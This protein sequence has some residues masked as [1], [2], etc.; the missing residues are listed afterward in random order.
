M[1]PLELF[2]SQSTGVVVIRAACKRCRLYFSNSQ[3]PSTGGGRH[4]RSATVDRRLGDA[5]T[6]VQLGKW[7]AAAASLCELNKFFK[8]QYDDAHR[9]TASHGGVPPDHVNGKA[10][11]VLEE[12]IHAMKQLNRCALA[13]V[14][15]DGSV[16]GVAQGKRCR[17]GAHGAATCPSA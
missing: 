1:P 13:H 17:C 12:W 9:K 11:L 7:Q 4:E 15:V 5:L 10:Q 3:G 6:L 16:H 14:V 2:Y 8:E